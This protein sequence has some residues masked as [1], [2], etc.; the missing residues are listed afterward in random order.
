MHLSDW[1]AGVRELEKEFEDG[2]L[3]KKGL[4]KKKWAIL[5]QHCDSSSS[6]IIEKLLARPVSDDFS[7]K[8]RVDQFVVLLDDLCTKLENKTTNVAEP[9]AGSKDGPSGDSG[10]ETT[11]D[12]VLAVSPETSGSS[13]GDSPAHQE[14]ATESQVMKVADDGEEGSSPKRRKAKQP[15]SNSKTP[16]STRRSSRKSA[17]GVHPQKMQSLLEPSSSSKISNTSAERSSAEIEEKCESTTP[18][19]DET[20]TKRKSLGDSEPDSEPE[21]PT[22]TLRARNQPT[23]KM[24]LEDDDEEDVVKVTRTPKRLSVKLKQENGLQRC[25]ICRQNLD[26]PDLLLFEGHPN[27]SVEEF[28]A[29][30]D[31][32]LTESYDGGELP[33]NK[34]THFSIYDENGHLCP[35]DSGIIEKNH[36]LRA[37]GY[38]KAVFEH[39]SSIEGG[40]AVKELGPINQWWIG[41]YD[42]GEKALVGISTD[43][44]EYFLM[45]PSL[46]YKPLMEALWEKIY[47]GKLVIEFIKDE[48]ASFEDL[49][50]HIQTT[51]PP[52]GIPKITE[53]TL[54]RHAQFVCDQV[55]S[56]DDA[57]YSSDESE[58]EDDWRKLI[59]VPCMRSL[60]S[61][62]GT[63]LSKR[64]AAVKDQ[65]SRVTRRRKDKTANKEKEGWS[66]ATT[67]A[68]VSDIFETFFKDQL[69]TKE[70]SLK[71]PKKL[72]CGVCE[73]CQQPDCGSCTNCKDMPKFG[74][75][76]KSKQGCVKRKCPYMSVKEEEANYESDDDEDRDVSVS[77]PKLKTR[78]LKSGKKKVEWIGEPSHVDETKNKKYY[79]KV[80]VGNE[81]ICVGDFV[82]CEA[83]EK[84]SPVVIGR[85]QFLWESNFGQRYMHL[86]WFSRGCETVLG[87]SADPQELFLVDQCENTL[88]NGIISKVTVQYKPVSPDWTIDG[89]KELESQDSHDDKVFFYSK[90][91]DELHGRFEDIPP[92]PA[93]PQPNL[94]YKY[95][96]SCLYSYQKLKYESPSVSEP[97]DEKT[98]DGKELYGLL[99]WRGEE[100]RK[101]TCVYIEPGTF[102]FPKGKK[103]KTASKKDEDSS[104]TSS[105]TD[106]TLYPEIYRKSETKG[107]ASNETTPDP[108]CIGLINAIA[109]KDDGLG[110]AEDVTLEVYKFY[111]PE[112]TRGIVSD[113]NV[114]D[115]TKLF[116]STEVVRVSFSQVKGKCY[117][118]YANNIPDG[119]PTGWSTAGPDRFY[120][121]EAYD[122]SDGSTKDP[123]RIFS[124]LGDAGKGGG[125]GKNSGNKSK[126]PIPTYPNISRPLRCL[127]V[128]AGCGGLSEG[129]HQSGI[130]ESKW[131]IEKVDTAASAFK[132]N[133]PDCTVFTDDCNNFLKA[134][135]S[136]DK[137]NELGQKYPQKG[138]VELM[139]GGPPC[140][141]FS[142]MN[143]FNSREYSKFKNS[144]IVS[145]LSFCDYYRPRFFI[146][147][148]VRNFV[149]FKRS[150]VLKLTLRCLLK[151][152]YQVTVGI[153]QAGHYGVP[154]TRR[155]AIIMAAAP[156]EV[157]PQ[158]PEPRHVFSPKTGG[159]S[160]VVDDKKIL[161]GCLFTDSAPL[162]TI[163]VYDSMSDLPEI[164]NGGN[165][166]EMDYGTDA[167]TH[168][169]KLMRDKTE[170]AKLRDHICKDMS[171]LVAARMAHV[172]KT[173][174][175]DWR[176]LPN[177][178]VQLGD[179][180]YS[181]KLI[182]THH[183]K[184]NGKSRKGALRGVCSC[185]TG[186]K[187]DPMDRQFN[188]LIPW[189]LPHTGN[190]HNHWAGLYGR[191]QWGEFF[192]TT[193]T[194]PE[195]MGKQG[196]VL[197]PV[198]NR[199]VS[200]RECAR[201]QG[202]PDR[203]KFFG[204]ILDKHRQVGNAVPPPM[205]RAIG[206]EIRKSVHKAEKKKADD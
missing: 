130:A 107:R 129:L 114:Y 142:G 97:L 128:F 75:T 154:Q 52:P 84:N 135:M 197:H 206:L 138:D 5:Q 110:A 30:T 140:Q 73:P 32:R 66:K 31:E 158:Y 171:A 127:D 123:I 71:G 121:E 22:R 167:I 134:V 155:R 174:N 180:T 152:G 192:S 188:T 118:A 196:R 172:P 179:G 150:M 105:S 122:S 186:G 74:G 25:K 89:G 176:D 81:E 83:N 50:N 35:L 203:F 157:L 191:L 85:V 29:L 82:S 109:S 48:D 146:L 47:L 76:G 16:E 139:V 201:S 14:V 113:L 120:F 93:N 68:L 111:R 38:V 60:I 166:E 80:N 24:K 189:C 163:T 184:K 132:L 64:K 2:D 88:L 55:V 126:V 193:V 11:D 181:K 195:P 117:V 159:L 61:L 37:S 69:D 96:C 149:S 204:H 12:I 49:L 185:A 169:Q 119:D 141:G 33:Q 148:N 104:I 7:E 100:Y 198:Q 15:R 70:V 51:V 1:R 53:E 115:L 87:E 79:Q 153:L 156:G 94:D 92:E 182:Y 147:E 86:Y 161:S 187:C 131:A 58:T 4:C 125:K 26:S 164:E 65:T 40:I 62:A 200:V 177:I 78:S 19:P 160:I 43:S 90:K 63:T 41:G 137:T 18:L 23:K 165:K 101:G 6:S 102:K 99:K 8:N 54:I 56:Y 98:D 112:N 173:K 175:A 145:Y 67:T 36:D 133:N 136:G 106:E 3:T 34:L 42:G 20:S 44:G 45:E 9:K 205:G 27:N 103:S 91:Y 108:F 190:R 59:T 17:G 28:I 168:F 72:R 178:A 124:S 199:V 162:R 95:C 46:E 202:F 183:D 39:D 151:M 13:A 21:T 194:N 10:N 143:R 170:G 144:L 77:D 116:A 57:G